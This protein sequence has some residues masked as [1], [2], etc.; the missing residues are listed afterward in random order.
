MNS[1]KAF[2]VRLL[3][4]ADVK[5]GGTR[6]WDIQVNNDRLYAKVLSR[7]TLGLGEAYMDGWWD[8]PAL[9]ELF[10]RL[11][12]S[13]IQ[14]NIRPSLNLVLN[15]VNAQLLNLQDRTRAFHVG[16]RH[17]DLGNDLYEAMLDK[18]MVYSCA[19]WKQAENLDEAQE[20]KLELI[21]RKLKLEPGMRILDIGCG[22]GGLAG[23]AAQH[24]GVRVVGLT[25]SAKQAEWARVQYADLPVEIRLEDYRRPRERFDRVVSVGMVEHVG[26]KNYRT[27]MEVAS[28]CLEPGGLFLL[29]TIGSNRSVHTGDPWFHRYI[30]PNGMLPS[31]AQLAGASEGLLRMEDL[32]NFGP[33]YDKT[34]M[35]WNRNFQAR[36]DQLKR[37]YPE[38]FYRMWTYYLLLSAAGFRSRNFQLW[39]IVF[40]PLG[41]THD[42]ERPVFPQEAWAVESIDRSLSAP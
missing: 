37:A 6:P 20:R 1:A 29:H 13:G 24:Y 42:Y 7:G 15:Y 11:L 39:Q 5:I 41:S 40:S 9:D 32:H 12:T 16:E 4:A 30:F 26:F 27:F 34:L 2:A 31:V 36:W 21:C 3:E 14:E 35:A 17:Y 28:R 8:C 10:Y 33:H 25:V 23:Y 18:R 38:R 22:W 19:Y